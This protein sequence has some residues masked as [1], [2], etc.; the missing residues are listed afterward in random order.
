MSWY[1]MENFLSCLIFSTI[2]NEHSRVPQ[3]HWLV[4]F[5]AHATGLFSKHLQFDGIK[6]GV[7]SPFIQ[8]PW[9]STK[10]G[11]NLRFGVLR[12]R[13]HDGQKEGGTDPLARW[14]RWRNALPFPPRND[15][16][17]QV[18]CRPVKSRLWSLSARIWTSGWLQSLGQVHHHRQCL[19]FVFWC[20]HHLTPN[21][22]AVEPLGGWR[23]ANVN[24][25]L[26]ALQW[27][28]YQEHQIPKQEASADRIRHACNGGEQ[29]VRTIV[30]FRGWVRS[31]DLY[32][33]VVSI[34]VVLASHALCCTRQRRR[35]TVSS[36][37]IQTHGSAQ[38]GLHSH[39]NVEVRMGPIGRHGWGGPTFSDLL[40]SRTTPGTPRGLL[41]RANRR[42]GP[43]CCGW[44]G[45]RDT[46]CGC[47]LPLPVG[48]QELPLHHRPSADHHSTRRPAPGVVFCHRHRGHS[49]PCWFVPP[50]LTRAQWPKTHLSSPPYLCTGRAGPTHAA[51]HSLRL[52]LGRGS[53]VTRDLV[54]PWA[55]QSGRKG[56]H[57]RQDPQSLAFSPGATPDVSLCR[58]RKHM[59]KV[60]A[61]IGGVAELVPNRGAETGLYSSLPGTGGHPTGYCQH[62]QKSRMLGH[63]Q[64][65]AKQVIHP[66][67]PSLIFLSFFSFVFFFP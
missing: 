31:L 25:S 43:A 36:H 56:V 37:S 9:P 49:S 45:W 2:Q 41:W 65:D 48:Q 46:L 5:L 52:S 6:E 24:Q 27:L 7:L 15:W 8:Y 18:R 59:V 67:F 55:G 51:S 33:L 50:R 16:L 13:W 35:R 3:I 39:G 62:C 44:G 63:G 58:L 47:H 57:A 11:L 23:G 32:R 34:M 38:S 19:Q 12:S 66:L 42:G 26:K 20:K 10:W 17:L 14:P 4:I 1:R 40:R 30:V 29:S 53:D 64:V 54:H 22:I 60:K 61:I 21:T 28:Y